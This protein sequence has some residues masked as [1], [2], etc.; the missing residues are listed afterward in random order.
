MLKNVKK[1]QK[2]FT[3]VELI[4]VIA[5]LGIL[6][7]LLVPR[8]MGNVNDAK[9]NKEISNARTIAS[10]IT[11]HNALAKSTEPEG[12]TIPAKLPDSGT[13]VV[14]VD[15]LTGVLVLPDGVN[16]PKSDIVDILVDSNGNASLD[17]K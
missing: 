5:I 6:A 1:N 17:I 14:K 13:A 12:T 3:L 2:G 7:T 10:E 9:K 4:V 8:I 16:F 11:T 15:D